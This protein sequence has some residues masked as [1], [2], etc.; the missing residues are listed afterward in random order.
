MRRAGAILLLGMLMTVTAR[1][2]GAGESSGPVVIIVLDKHSGRPLVGAPLRLDGREPVLL[3]DE[4]GRLRLEQ[5]AAGSHEISI[6]DPEHQP[7][8]RR[9]ELEAG[10]P[11]QL[12]FALDR[13]GSDEEEQIVIRAR[14]STPQVSEKT[15]EVE[16]VKKIAGTQGDIVKIVQSLPGV[17]RG[18]AVGGSGG[19]GLV[20]R[21]AAPEDSRVLIDGHEIPILYHFGGLKSVLNSDMLKRIDFL[22]GGFG[23]AFGEAIGGIVDVETRSARGEGFAGYLES[24]LLDL[25]FFLEGPIGGG[26]SFIA[27]ARRSTVDLWL[28]HVL[29]ESLG[30]ELTVAPVYYDYQLKVDWSPRPGDRISLLGFGSHDEMKFLLNKP[31][32]GDPSLRGDMSMWVDFQRLLLTWNHAPEQDWQLR[33]SLAAGWDRAK[34]VIGD[35]RHMYIDVPNFEGRLDWLWDV[36]HRLRLRAGL[37]S[38]GAFFSASLS[39]PR[40]PKEGELPSR[41]AS[42][43]LLVGS[44]TVST[45]SVFGYLAADLRPL[46]HLLLSSGLRVEWYGPPLW[47]VAVMPR[48]SLRY[49]ARTGTVLKAAVGLYQ[50]TPQEDELSRVLG[51]PDLLLERGWHFTLGLEQKLVLDIK[52]DL[53]VFYKTLD[54][55]VVSDR[56][57]MYSNRGIG[58]ISGL[59]I[60]LKREGKRVFGW[61]AYTFM[62]SQRR[63]GPDQPWRLFAFDQTHILTLV[64]GWRLP[65]GPVRKGYGQQGGWQFGLRYQLVSGNPYTPVVDAVFDA[66][67]DV[68]QRIPGEPLSRRL[69]L[70]HQLDLRVDYT[71]AFSSWAL[72]L[73]LDVQN[74]Y[75]HRAAEQVRYNYDATEQA[76]IEGLP[77]LP[78]L[79]VKG[80]F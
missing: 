77:I 31:P 65:T 22:P 69:P 46:P 11:R 73:F 24:S 38:G 64:A 39:M 28:P 34:V 3:T 71:W 19:V 29:P 51:N 66:D 56:Q 26:V 48:F 63:D 55:L 67:Y 45:G 35:D 12:R 8:R 49:R 33:C 5:L 53:D 1:P 6:F 7:F 4:R 41:F 58:D 10:Q 52:A 21:G 72:T 79:G 2:A 61:L 50:Q 20:V 40:P 76:Y 60:L 30:L 62:R 37:E 13:R 44:E 18:L 75:N 9:F 25:G 68:Y 70:F 42:Q 15:L 80:C 74:A 16:Q 54:R 36:S 59:E 57:T 27:A 43:K 78:Y 23:P 17:A 32:S 47:Q 14:R